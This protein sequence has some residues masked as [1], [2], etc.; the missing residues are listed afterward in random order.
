MPVDRRAAFASWPAVRCGAALDPPGPVFCD[1]L[2]THMIR[3]P[4]CCDRRLFCVEHAGNKAVP[5]SDGLPV[6]LVTVSCVVTIAAAADFP[7]EAKAE[8]LARLREAAGAAG[9]VLRM[10]VVG[11]AVAAYY[12]SLGATVG[13]SG[14]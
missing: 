6:Q 12:P 3:D 1:E 11:A 4:H 14:R 10:D 8:A 13:P 7:H 2:A 5:I 9:F